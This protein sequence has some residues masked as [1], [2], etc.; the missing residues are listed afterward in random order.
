MAALGAA[1]A[2]PQTANP[3]HANTVFEGVAF[4]RVRAEGRTVLEF[5]YIDG[6]REAGA[7]VV[8]R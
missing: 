3:G 6:L 7:S 1:G 4:E 8:A 2:R 5:V